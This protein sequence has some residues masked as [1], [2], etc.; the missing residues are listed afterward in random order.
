MSAVPL[1]VPAQDCPMLACR[2]SGWTALWSAF[3]A[4]FPCATVHVL[5]VV[6]AA[7]G[8]SV[9]V[10]GDA[11]QRLDIGRQRCFLQTHTDMRSTTGSMHRTL[12]L[13]RFQVPSDVV[14]RRLFDPRQQGAG[15]AWESGSSGAY[16]CY[17]LT[18]HAGCLERVHLPPPG[19]HLAPHKVRH[20]R[21]RPAGSTDCMHDVTLTLEHAALQ[22][23]Q[24]HACM[25][26][27]AEAEAE[28]SQ[29]R[30]FNG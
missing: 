30:M 29:Q 25:Q 12:V 15:G 1:V 19:L 3:G 8:C 20:G 5:E 10:A 27:M 22:G 2:T 4:A 24:H 28:A 18:G 11:R 14:R 6:P 21:P 17:L 9:H 7:S 13:P 23:S 16:A 26:R